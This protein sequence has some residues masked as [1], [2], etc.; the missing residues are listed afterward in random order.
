MFGGFIITIERH[1]MEIGNNFEKLDITN[2]G[3]Q[4]FDQFNYAF[5]Y[6]DRI[7][8]SACKNNLGN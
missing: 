5:K 4:K 8:F 3:Y 6:K 7:L 1:D 2:I